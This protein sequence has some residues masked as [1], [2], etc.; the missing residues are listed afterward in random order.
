[1]RSGA[2]GVKR[3]DSRLEKK[4]NIFFLKW[5]GHFRRE[6]VAKLTKREAPMK[7]ANDRRLNYRSPSGKKEVEK[8]SG[9]GGGGKDFVVCSGVWRSR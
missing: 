6:R 5:C 9:G 4:V 3:Q 2:D 8:C 1:M 7:E